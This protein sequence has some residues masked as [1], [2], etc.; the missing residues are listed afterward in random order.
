MT[1]ILDGN[2]SYFIFRINFALIAFFPKKSIRMRLDQK[3]W[4]IEVTM[5]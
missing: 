4:R 2:D 5:T 1:T 3:L